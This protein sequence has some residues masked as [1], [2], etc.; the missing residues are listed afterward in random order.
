[1]KTEYR[2]ALQLDMMLLNQA[3]IVKILKT[4]KVLKHQQLISE[5]V[6]QILGQ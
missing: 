1:M 3:A 5:V 2:Q 4:R 6:N